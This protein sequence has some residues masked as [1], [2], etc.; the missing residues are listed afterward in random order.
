MGNLSTPPSVQE[1]QTALHAKAKEDPSFRFYALYDKVHREDV[2]Q[3][4]YARCKSNKGAAGVDEERF[5]DIESYGLDL[6]LGELA[7]E[8]REKTYEPQAVRR[9]WI[10]KPNG[11]LRPLG[12]APIRDR[13]AQTAAVLILEPIFE[14][15]LQPEQHAYRPVRN[16][17]TAVTEV[18]GLLCT[19]HTHVIDADLSAYFD[20]IPHA[21]LLHSVAR[22][23]VDRQMLHLVKMWL[24][25]AVE[26]TDER[27]RK[28]RTTRNRDEKRGIPQGSPLSPQLSNLYMRRFVLGWKLLGYEQQFGA[29]IVNYADDLVICCRYQAEE[30]LQA[31]R[32]IMK[33]L[34]LTVN[35]EKTS[36]CRAP[37]EHFDFLGYTFGQCYS[38]KTGRAYIGTR[39]S[40]K[41]IKRLIV[42][43]REQTEPRTG[44]LDADMIVP[45]INRKLMGWAQYFKLGPVSSAY[46]AIDAYTIKR[47]R[48]WLCRKHK[49]QGS[50][51]TRY[52]D[53]YFTETLGLVRL[54]TLTSSL[55]WAQA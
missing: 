37:A 41:S 15:D 32:R 12:I 5:E 2:L 1:L 23:V 10:P 31:M 50:G 20:T 38:F 9:V 39:P 26:E 14:T 4:A 21:E 18:H 52:P 46:R 22:R 17:L 6:W 34:K 47:L 48:R 51:R 45:D 28:M 53:Q 24:E 42:A 16:A 43:I 3:Y 11:K 33:R 40:R 49:V 8:L 25:A 44:L 36:I 35:E 54:P 19:G 30:A 7:K 55:P 27:G 13:V 29:K